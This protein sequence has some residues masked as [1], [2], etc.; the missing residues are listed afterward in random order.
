MHRQPIFSECQVVGGSVAEELFE[1]GLYLSSGSNLTEA[2]L[3]RVVEVVR[4]LR[5]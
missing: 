5:R 1:H 2:D 4:S 3:S